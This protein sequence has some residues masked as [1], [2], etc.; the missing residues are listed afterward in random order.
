MKAIV[1]LG[2]GKLLNSHALGM[3]LFTKWLSN[4]AVYKV[5]ET[6]ARITRLDSWH[7]THRNQGRHSEHE[8]DCHAHDFAP[9]A[10]DRL[11]GTVACDRMVIDMAFFNATPSRPEHCVMVY[12][13]K[14][15]SA[16]SLD[17]AYEQA[18]EYV[19]KR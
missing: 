9:D 4:D 11:V 19:H 3:A 6:V 14:S 10:W 13:A 17:K 8:I 16:V 12:E 18:L 15:G 5:V 1:A 2:V 7:G